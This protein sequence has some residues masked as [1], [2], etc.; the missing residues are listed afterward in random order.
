MTRIK[1]LG[2]SL[3]SVVTSITGML[4]ISPRE[5]IT[6]LLIG[7]I[8]MAISSCAPNYKVVEGKHKRA[9]IVSQQDQKEFKGIE[10][11]NK[12]SY[13]DIK[14]SPFIR[15]LDSTFQKDP[16][17]QKKVEYLVMA[18]LTLNMANEG[19]RLDN[20]EKILR[21]KIPQDQKS[22]DREFQKVFENYGK[23]KLVDYTDSMKW[24]NTFVKDEISRRAQ[25]IL[26]LGA[27]RPN[28]IPTLDD[29]F[30]D[31]A[32][33]GTAQLIK[34]G[35]E[36]VDKEDRTIEVSFGETQNRYYTQEF[37]G[38]PHKSMA[39]N[40]KDTDEYKLASPAKKEQ[41]ERQHKFDEQENW[42]QR[43][44]R[45]GKIH[46]PITFV[47]MDSINTMLTYFPVDFNPEDG[48][49][50]AEKVALSLNIA[51][52]KLANPDSTSS[53]ID[54]GINTNVIELKSN[55]IIASA[56]DS[57]K[58]FLPQGTDLNESMQTRVYTTP[59]HMNRSDTADYLV[60]GA[61]KNNRTGQ[62][63]RVARII[64][65]PSPKGTLKTPY[66]ESRILG[67]T[68]GKPD[69]KDLTQ[70][71]KN[72]QISNNIKIRPDQ[73]N[74]L[75]LWSSAQN[76]T[77]TTTPKDTLYAAEV[78]VFITESDL[79]KKRKGIIRTGRAYSK[80]IDTKGD[81]IWISPENKERGIA[82]DTLRVNPSA[83]D[84]REITQ[85]FPNF[86]GTY[87]IESPNPDTHY[88]VGFQIPDRYLT[89]KARDK[90]YDIELRVYG[91]GFNSRK[92]DPLAKSTIE[93]I[94][95]QKK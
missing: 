53:Y 56:T 72:F 44:K 93:R 77:K 46:N 1:N 20:L 48:K 19:E 54:L 67:C 22:I 49:F 83:L 85:Q 92:I 76:L 36:E 60:K 68:Q 47:K 40:F 65:I 89:S 29:L 57:I 32:R 90:E 38:A 10:D 86:V 73:K 51:L 13:Y 26:M 35:G 23:W 8:L 6:Y 39:K 9:R 79:D 3:E 17:A 80:F 50:D 78:D 52:K 59:F 91:T 84:K 58:G 69:E 63:A 66:F 18:Y 33:Q 2:K 4:P 95:F 16:R 37:S 94:K 41:M 27:Y 87:T 55:E 7:G 45:E 70:K 64:T 74:V 31:I 30:K 61:V 42:G 11:K 71:L 12:I 14:N 25:N 24:E 43:M 81:T 62:E 75:Y 88:F 28:V 5:G 34:M 15:S 82:A 21:M